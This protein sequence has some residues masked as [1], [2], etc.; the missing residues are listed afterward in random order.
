MYEKKIPTLLCDK[1]GY[2]WNCS[3]KLIHKSQLDG[4]IKY[5]FE[6]VISFLILCSL[7]VRTM[8]TEKLYCVLYN[9]FGS[10]HFEFL[11]HSL[12]C[13]NLSFI[14]LSMAYDI[15][16][17]L[18][19]KYSGV[20]GV[21]YYRIHPKKIKNLLLSLLIGKSS[22]WKNWKYFWCMMQMNIFTNKLKLPKCNTVTPCPF[23]NHQK[24]KTIRHF[25][26]RGVFQSSR[27]SYKESS[28]LLCHHSTLKKCNKLC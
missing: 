3:L 22:I 10:S 16:V 12:P 8:H 14:Q 24:A 28:F 19:I 17:S 1:A 21:I 13:Y 11:I 2:N 5:V 27:K 26:V 6:I 9:V 25:V 4:L 18:T 7:H 20:F 15:W 23:C